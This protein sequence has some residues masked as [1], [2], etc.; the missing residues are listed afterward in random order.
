MAKNNI[1]KMRKKRNMTQRA[2]SLVTGIDVTAISRYENEKRAVPIE[3]Y[4]KIAK[5]LKTTPS[6]L[7]GWE[8]KNHRL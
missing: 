3:S 4:E 7:A 5:A 6:Y 8:S 1:R 2:L